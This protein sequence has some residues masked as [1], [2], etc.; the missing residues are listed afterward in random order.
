VEAAAAPSRHPVGRKRGDS[1]VENG[2][3]IKENFI[4]RKFCA[5]L[6]VYRPHEHL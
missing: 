6:N 3:K 4:C 2:Q 1:A 5:E